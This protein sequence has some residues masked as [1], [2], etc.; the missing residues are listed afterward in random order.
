VRYEIRMM[1]GKR[2]RVGVSVRLSVTIF[3]SRQSPQT[4]LLYWIDLMK[5]YLGRE[6]T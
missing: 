4:L 1:A 2:R 6:E 3:L 5:F